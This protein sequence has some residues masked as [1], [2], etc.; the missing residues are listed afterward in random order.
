MPGSMFNRAV[1]AFRKGIIARK[2][3]SN[4][5]GPI[6]DDPQDNDVNNDND[7]HDLV[8]SATFSVVGGTSGNAQMLNG[9]KSVQY[10]TELGDQHHTVNSERD[11][12]THCDASVDVHLVSCRCVSAQWR[13]VVRRPSDGNVRVVWQLLFFRWAANICHTFL[14]SDRVAVF[15]FVVT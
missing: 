9:K 12:Q 7:K 4:S 8:A 6:D 13:S 3:Q 5:A 11:F 14:A 15:S 2:S 1:N 10:L